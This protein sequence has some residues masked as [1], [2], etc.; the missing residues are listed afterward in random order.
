MTPG[1]V[2]EQQTGLEPARSRVK[3]WSLVSLHSA[4]LTDE[5]PP[6]NLE[7]S[8]GFLAALTAKDSSCPFLVGC[9]GI[10]PPTISL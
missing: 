6:A 4:V 7:I 3:A 1:A 2:M 9:D 8:G 10:E 5:P